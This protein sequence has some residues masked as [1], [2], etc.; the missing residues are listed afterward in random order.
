LQEQQGAQ[1][2]AAQIDSNV[3]YRQGETLHGEGTYT[4]RL[5]MWDLS[6]ALGGVSA[7]GS[8]YRDSG[9]GSDVVSTWGGR[10]EV[11]RAAAVPKSA[12]AAELEQEAERQEA[13]GAQ[14]ELSALEVAAQQLEGGSSGSGQASGSSGGGV[15]YFTDYL[16]AHLHPRSV[17]QLPGVWHG[18]TPFGGWG[19]AGQHCRVKDEVEGMLERI[20]CSWGLITMATGSLARCLGQP[21]PFFTPSLRPNSGGP[22]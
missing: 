7:G 1:G 21:T 5:V 15:R 11:H 2:P 8:L 6:G 3:L 14:G 22:R 20:R 16:K 4:P 9:H 12:F 10:Q 17:Q 19:D 13:E 18:L